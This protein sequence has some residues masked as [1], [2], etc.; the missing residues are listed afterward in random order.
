MPLS[1]FY[2]ILISSD[3]KDAVLKP[4]RRGLLFRYGVDSQY[5]EVIFIMKPGFFY[6]YSTRQTYFEHFF[7]KNKD[8]NYD[9][10]ST[11]SIELKEK[12]KKDAN[13]FSYRILNKEM[14][15]AVASF[16]GSECDSDTW[17]NS[18]CNMQMIMHEDVYFNDVLFVLLP[19]WI[20]EKTNTDGLADNIPENLE[21]ICKCDES[22]FNTN[23]K[24]FLRDK[25][26]Y[27]NAN[28]PDSPKDN[29]A[30]SY[31]SQNNLIG[32]YLLE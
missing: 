29:N 31:Y 27:Y 7:L 6:K 20:K 26:K 9:R 4:S 19:E 13:M 14:R 30:D 1:I 25:F 12:L 22:I 24:N 21:K 11:T 15:N 18:W 32:N 2:K 8:G 17:N 5:G 3:D 10:Y 16:S 28:L 23:N